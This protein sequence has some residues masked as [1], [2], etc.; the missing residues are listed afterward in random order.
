MLRWLS[1]RSCADFASRRRPMITP[2]VAEEFIR[3]L[4]PQRLAVSLELKSVSIQIFEL[5]SKKMDNQGC[6]PKLPLGIFRALLFA[7]REH[8]SR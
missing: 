8:R 1:E 2:I 6:Y 4:A 7:V 3:I 5:K